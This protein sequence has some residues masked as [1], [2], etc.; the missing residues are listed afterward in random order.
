MGF[1]TPQ[2][3]SLVCVRGKV[4]QRLGRF[5]T[6]RLKCRS[7]LCPISLT[8]C[9]ILGEPCHFVSLCPHLL[10]SV[11]AWHTGPVRG[12]PGLLGTGTVAEWGPES[13]AWLSGPVDIGGWGGS[14]G[15]PPTSQADSDPLSLRQPFPLSSRN[16][17]GF[18]LKLPPPQ[19]PPAGSADCLRRSWNDSGGS[20]SWGHVSPF[21]GGWEALQ[22][23][24]RQAEAAGRDQPFE[25]LP[26]AP[27]RE[28]HSP[29]LPSL[30]GNPRSRAP[31]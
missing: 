9:R 5:V 3:V 8:N 30:P 19:Q 1:A 16:W 21:T 31:P 26:P 24:G 18:S 14:L 6:N 2:G 28:L 13:P 10:G 22:A 7:R 17:L 27:R 20:G 25:A 15:V 12:S 23:A 11:W 4:G 29:I